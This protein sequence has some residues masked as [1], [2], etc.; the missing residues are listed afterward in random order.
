MGEDTR[1]EDRALG[2]ERLGISKMPMATP[3]HIKDIWRIRCHFKMGLR[4]KPQT[5]CFEVK[6]VKNLV[7]VMPTLEKRIAMK[8]RAHKQNGISKGNNVVARQG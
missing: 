7:L 5:M 4:L 3:M 6:V 8:E 1:C 2:L